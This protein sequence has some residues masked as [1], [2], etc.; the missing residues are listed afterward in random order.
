MRALNLMWGLHRPDDALAVNRAAQGRCADRAAA[1]SWRS[2]KRAAH[3]LRSAGR[4]PGRP[5]R[6]GRD[7]RPPRAARCTR[8]PRCRRSPRPGSPRLRSV[9]R[10]PRSPSTSSCRPRWRSPTRAAHHQS[11]LRPDR[12][13]TGSRG[14]RARRRG[15]PGHAGRTRPRR[16]RC[17]SRT[18]SAGA[19]SSWARRDRAAV[20]RR[21]GGPVRG[22]RLRRAAPAGVVVARDRARVARRCR[23]GGRGGGRSRSA[24]RSSRTPRAEQEFGRAWALVAAGD[25]PGARATCCSRQPTIA[26]Q[27]RLP[28]HRSV[29][30]ARCRAAR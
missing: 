5:R 7:R 11:D 9:S 29:A 15:V 1:T 4:R 8:S 2:G 18:C 13:R 14:V 16:R 10:A 12:G 6:G 28:R 27:Y 24:S 20:A 25:V 17:G 22:A 21:G 3:V 19:R 23:G 26:A 30:A